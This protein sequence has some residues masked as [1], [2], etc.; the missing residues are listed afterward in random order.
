MGPNLP[1]LRA[2]VTRVESL[3]PFADV[4][5]AA[6][7]VVRR[8]FEALETDAEVFERTRDGRPVLAGGGRV[9]YLAGWPDARALDRIVR[10]EAALGGL[11][12]LDLP[13]RA[14]GA[15]YR[16]PPFLVQ[17]RERGANLRRAHRGTRRRA[18]G[19]S[20]PVMPHR[21]KGGGVRRRRASTGDGPG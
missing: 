11:P 21:V 8:W 7:G 4:P 3:P 14:Q 16:H 17:L 2:T 6:G 5:L 15:R 20:G 19:A 13:P 18:L 10:R 9:G 12:A 1:G